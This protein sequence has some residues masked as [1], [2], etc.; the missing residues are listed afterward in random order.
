MPNW[1]IALLVAVVTALTTTLVT[2]LTILPRLEARNRKIQA[3]HQD[4]ERYGQ[5]VLTILTCSARLTNLVIPDEASPTVR[6]ALI[7]EGERWRQKIDTATKDLADSIAPLS[8]IWFLKDVALRFAL[9]SRLVWISERSESA[10][11]AALLDLSG[12]A[13]GLF[14]AAWWRRPKRAKCMRQLVQLTDDLEAHRR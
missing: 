6:E 2:S 11:L 4:R 8:Y 9:V 5:A 10:K 13:Q 14:F 12:A 7:G 1:L 3:G